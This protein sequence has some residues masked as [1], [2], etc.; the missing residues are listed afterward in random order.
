[1]ILRIFVLSGFRKTDP[2]KV[3][4]NIPTACVLDGM[5]DAQ[6]LTSREFKQRSKVY[7]FVEGA[8]IVFVAKPQEIIKYL[9]AR[10]PWE[11]YDICLFDENMEWCIGLTHN[12]V[13]P[14]FRRVGGRE[15]HRDGVVVHVQAD[16][17][18]RAFEGRW[19]S[20]FWAER[21]RAFLR[22]DRFGGAQYVCLHGV[23]FPFIRWLG[24][25]SHNWWLGTVHAVQPTFT[26]ESR[27]RFHFHRQPYCLGIIERHENISANFYY[28]AA[29]SL[30]VSLVVWR[31][32]NVC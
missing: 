11:D 10:Q 30:G 6:V 4:S 16:E 24:R 14:H 17:Q 1:M 31:L 27:H 22:L 12:P 25:E 2:A 3:P 5:L 26:P 20:G 9:S 8:G 18:K 32:Q 13:A 28:R 21:A 19:S 23:C 15:A 29:V 7:V